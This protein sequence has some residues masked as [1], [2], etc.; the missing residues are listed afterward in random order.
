MKTP[1]AL[2]EK[3]VLND[4][5]KN[6]IYYHMVHSNT[7]VTLEVTVIVIIFTNSIIQMHFSVHN[8]FFIQILKIDF[9]IK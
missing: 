5:T 6:C 1:K 4:Y 9:F 3:T 2:E 7:K 8:N